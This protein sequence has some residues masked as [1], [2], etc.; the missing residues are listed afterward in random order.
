MLLAGKASGNTI[1]NSLVI[2][3]YTS[4][5]KSKVRIPVLG[6]RGVRSDMAGW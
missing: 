6:G 4:G 1:P 5:E 2:K 3:V